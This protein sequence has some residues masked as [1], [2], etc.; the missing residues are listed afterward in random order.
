MKREREKKKQSRQ[1][2]NLGSRQEEGDGGQEKFELGSENA[3]CTVM[4]VGKQLRDI[5][6]K[7]LQKEWKKPS[8]RENTIRR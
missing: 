2:V 7:G 6:G 4:E 8:V 1:A 3:S 5:M